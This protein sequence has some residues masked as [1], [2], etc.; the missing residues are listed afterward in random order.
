MNCLLAVREVRSLLVIATVAMLPGSLVI[1]SESAPSG[2]RSV[3]GVPEFRRIFVPADQPATWPTGGDRYLP[4]SESEFARLLQTATAGNK[5]APGEFAPRIEAARYQA[6][7]DT[8]GNLSGDAE[9]EI[10]HHGAGPAL[11]RLSPWSLVITDAR[12]Q[13]TDEKP[14]ANAAR[15]TPAVIGNLPD[16]TLAVLVSGSGKLLLQWSLIGKRSAT[17]TPLF[18]FEVCSAVSSRLELVAPE[19][20]VPEMEQALIVDA[21][22]G[23][24]QRRWTVD[25]GGRHG[26]ELRLAGAAAQDQRNRL[27]LLRQEDAYHLSRR[28]LDC[29]TTLKIVAHGDSLSSIELEI[30]PGLELTAV[31][32]DRQQ[33]V[34]S[35]GPGKLGE[36]RH[37]RVDLPRPISGESAPIKLSA[38]AALPLGKHV[39]LPRLRVANLFWQ[40]GSVTLSIE[41]PL[42]LNQLE[43]T[44]ARPTIGTASGTPGEGEMFHLQCLSA[45]DE[46]RIEADYPQ[47]RWSVNE[48]AYVEFLSGEVVSHSV[49]DFTLDGPD[50]DQVACRV[51]PDWQIDSVEAEL[52][53]KVSEWEVVE[54]QLRRELLIRLRAGE[55]LTSKVRLKVTGRKPFPLLES[56][57]VRELS[58]LSYPRATLQAQSLML[59]TP[60]AL[61]IQSH[62]LEA[63]H[64]IDLKQLARDNPLFADPMPPGIALEL[65]ADAEHV[66]ISVIPRRPQFNAEVRIVAR[67]TGET[68]EETCEVVC[69]PS[70]AVLDRLLVH[71]SKSTTG[72]PWTWTGNNALG[73]VTVRKLTADEQRSADAGTEGDAWELSWRLPQRERVTLRGTRR[74]KLG[75][76]SP[77]SLVTVP[78]AATQTGQLQIAVEDATEVEVRNTRLRAVPSEVAPPGVIQRIRGTYQFDPGRH[79]LLRDPA[80]MIVR[81]DGPRAGQQAWVTEATLDTRLFLGAAAQHVAVF[82][83]QTVGQPFAQFT[84]PAD[85]T[86]IAMEVNGTALENATDQLDHVLKIRMPE[87]AAQASVSLCF[88]TQQ[89]LPKFVEQLRPEFPQTDMKVLS[90]RWRL[91]LPVSYDAPSESLLANRYCRRTASWSER[92]FGPLGRSEHASVRNPFRADFWTQY[93]TSR[94]NMEQA[95]NA[96]TQVLQTLG[97]VEPQGSDTTWGEAL[98]RAAGTKQTE[99][100]VSWSGLSEAGVTANDL[101]PVTDASDPIQRGMERLRKHGLSLLVRGRCVLVAAPPLVALNRRALWQLDGLPAYFVGDGVLAAELDQ[102]TATPDNFLRPAAWQLATAAQPPDVKRRFDF[103]AAPEGATMIELRGGGESRLA[104]SV[105]HQP[106]LFVVSAAV[107]LLVLGFGIFRFHARGRF[108]PLVVAIGFSVALLIPLAWA[109]LAAAIWTASAAAWLLLAVRGAVRQTQPPRNTQEP[110]QSAVT[111]VLLSASSFLIVLLGVV[112]SV[113]A[114]QS[115]PTGAQPVTTAAVKTPDPAPEIV[116]VLV[117]IDQAQ[118]SVGT[119]VYLPETFYATLLSVAERVREVPR[120]WLL[121]DARYRAT[122]AGDLFQPE[123]RKLEIQ[124]RFKVQVFETN[125]EVTLPVGDVNSHLVEG[126]VLVDGR[127]GELTLDPAHHPTVLIAEPGEHSIEMLVEV[128]IRILGAQAG[129]DL[130]IP[131]VTGSELELSGADAL[132]VEVP[133]TTEKAATPDSPAQRLLLVGNTTRLAIRWPDAIASDAAAEPSQIEELYWAHVKPGSVTLDARLF[134]RTTGAA[135]HGLQLQI[136]SSMTLLDPQ[137]DLR[138]VATRSVPG[139]RQL[140]DL[141]LRTPIVDQRMIELHFV[142]PGITGTGNLRLPLCQIVGTHSAKRWYAVSV[143]PVLSFV[144]DVGEGAEIMNTTDFVRAW[145]AALAEPQLAYRLAPASQPIAIS[146]Q[147]KSSVAT[148]ETTL[149]LAVEPTR[150]DVVWSANI[151]AAEHEFQW[152]LRLPS[153]LMVSALTMTQPHGAE[154]PLRWSRDRDASFI[155]A[156]T[157]KPVRGEYRVTVRGWVTYEPHARL[158]IPLIESDRVE[159]VKQTLLVYQHRHVQATVSTDANWEASAAEP[160][161]VS[162]DGDRLIGEW[163][164]TRRDAGASLHVAPNAVEGSATQ[165]VTA[166]PIGDQWA[167]EIDTHLVVRSG[168]VDRL[169]FDVPANWSALKLASDQAAA[170]LT[171]VELPERRL[172]RLTVRPAD[173]IRTE[174]R[175]RILGQLPVEAGMTVSM[176]TLMLDGLD[177]RNFMLLPRNREQD[178]YQWEL[179]QLVAAELP[180]TEAQIMHPSKDYQSYR[181]VGDRPKAVLRE[182]GA[183]SEAARPLHIEH[184]FRWTADGSYFGESTWVLDR[185]P[186]STVEIEL[187]PAMTLLHCRVGGIPVAMDATGPQHYRISLP[188]TG[189]PQWIE[190]MVTGQLPRAPLP[191]VAS[192]W[193]A[194]Q[195]VGIHPGKSYWVVH[196][197]FQ[198]TQVGDTQA[199]YRQDLLVSRLAAANVMIHAGDSNLPE[200]WANAFES[201]M[202]GVSLKELELLIANGQLP[203]STLDNMDRAHAWL[204][205]LRLSSEAAL[206]APFSESKSRS[207]QDDLLVAVTTRADGAF[208]IEAMQAP[209]SDMLSRITLALVAVFLAAM[210]AAGT[211]GTQR[212]QVPP[213]V[214]GILVAFIL[215]VAVEPLLLPMF[216]LIL[217]LLW[218]IAPC[219]RTA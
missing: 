141:E 118:H 189:T 138:V 204:A 112:A 127:V 191:G 214:A 107:A 35:V 140:V 48:G 135:I 218:I 94:E 14:Q 205:P 134:I 20:I 123:V 45:N 79:G 95:G 163:V 67:V 180:A 106:A 109:P 211:T 183:G 198:A 212:L 100:Y 139:N 75:Q 147:P 86:L 61:Q 56:A 125:T 18:T 179:S 4:I 185:S 146:T 168:A 111:Q 169:T 136:D 16:G 170:T 9:L 42:M 172:Q 84:L 133:G 92:L 72:T 19:E 37:V 43:T 38:I 52:P 120:G 126:S 187:P 3:A 64:L 160:P 122:V 10:Q 113:T 210:V 207:M 117:P 186:R 197:P 202:I 53:V 193:A 77:I 103:I 144:R 81:P 181:S 1:A 97:D 12:W 88:Q 96:A 150:M 66:M 148:A 39:V 156:T 175:Y 199:S 65:N 70:G 29:T 152:Q 137:P 69:L 74:T 128:P 217:T 154:V 177:V 30:D 89:H 131:R 215:W 28:G 87:R 44:G 46:I 216:A 159:P 76:S 119:N 184:C 6:S 157:S 85:A 91:W 41:P 57:G 5:S 31:T 116:R 124:A 143:D 174:C 40:E 209:A 102:P 132:R 190:L 166:K 142:I 63:A 219:P 203:A 55:E 27:A 8:S 162:G 90:R 83:I 21:P 98:T 49:A 105:V 129:V 130:A 158:E 58:M 104:V 7:L 11:V 99:L 26:G 194:P 149:S 23:S 80:I 145:N 60:E 200:R 201:R 165:V 50:A 82:Q 62:G 188:V 195:I 93:R 54:T 114:Q 47:T 213:I 24:G 59:Q 176:P 121:T 32:L 68:L 196:N 101:L 2:N 206:R 36:R 151:S 78:E 71:T 17:G 73:K 155:H 115:A 153:T 161:A 13:A 173:P 171:S 34:W 167:V 33:L 178:R 25:L 192:N 108:W 15:G 22:A 208:S 182:T 110:Q 51:N 164:T